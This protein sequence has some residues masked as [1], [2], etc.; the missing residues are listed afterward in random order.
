MVASVSALAALQPLGQRRVGLLEDVGGV[1]EL[2]EVV[3]AVF[4]PLSYDLHARLD[5]CEDVHRILAGGELRLDTGNDFGLLQIT[6]GLG[7]IR[8][9]QCGASLR[10]TF[11]RRMLPRKL[12]ALCAA[13]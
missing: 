10:S 3:L 2:G 5:L 1:E 4:E 6:Q 8:R 7:Q 12:R 9:A 13:E 11:R